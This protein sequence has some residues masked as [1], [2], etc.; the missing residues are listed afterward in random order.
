MP[1]NDWEQDA[2]GNLIV[3]P[4]Q[5]YET[6]LFHGVGICVRLSVLDQTA[7]GEVRAM[8]FQIAL[9][10]VSARALAQSLLQAADRA[11][12]PPVSTTMRQ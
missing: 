3:C 7:E 4:L 12:Q 1:A 8:N 5:G 9:T 2:E 6:A 10:P 11:E